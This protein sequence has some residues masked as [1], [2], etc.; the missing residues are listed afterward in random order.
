MNLRLNDIATIYLVD[1]YLGTS[2]EI[3][4]TDSTMVDFVVNTDA[5]SYASNRFYIVFN[6]KTTN[7]HLQFVIADPK[8]ETAQTLKLKPAENSNASRIYI[9]PNPVIN[10]TINL[11]TENY[12][13]GHYK[14]AISDASG[15]LVLNKEISLKS[16]LQKNIIHLGEHF[17]IGSYHL[18]ISSPATISTLD[19]IV[20]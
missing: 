4:K 11:F 13:L 9:A 10:K 17:S 1:N 8:A 12:S 20:E 7:H 14:L 16:P 3:N 5:L 18:S 15:K 6:K 19:F 2:T